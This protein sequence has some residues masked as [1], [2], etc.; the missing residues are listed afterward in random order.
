MNLPPPT[1][2]A[3]RSRQGSVLI[4]VLWVCVGLVSIALYFANTMGFEL[5]ASDN[6]VSGLQ[7]D[8]A[9][10]GAAR[11][12]GL[13]LLNFATNGTVPDNTQF[14]CEAVPVG[15]ARFWLLGRDPSGT[16]GP[17]PYFG[18]VD[19]GA[20]L[21]L[22]NASTNV[23]QYLPNMTIDFADAILDWRSTNGVV[24]LDYTSL[25]YQTK[26]APFETVDE[27]RLVYG[28]SLEFLA[29]E[30]VNR[31]GILDKNEKDLN[32]SGQLDPGLFEY[33]TVYTR[34]PNFHADGTTLTNVNTIS[35]SE[36]RSLFQNA[37]TSSAARMAQ[38]LYRSIHPN[39][40][41]PRTVN[42]CNGL[43][44][45]ALRCKN[46]GLS[47]DDFAKLEPNV[48][49]STNAYFRGRVNVN[50]AGVDVLTA[51]FMGAGQDEQTALSAA[52][53]LIT[54]R[55]QNLSRLGS[56]TW[57]IDALGNNQPIITAMARRNDLTTRSYQFTADIAA[58]GPFG[59]GYRRVK[60]I[61]DISDG[62]PK[63]LY[64]QD[65][66]RLGW[67]LGEKARTTL[68]AKNTQ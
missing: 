54:Y 22:N 51:L 13:A 57:V 10:E 12:V 41:N 30:D 58:V 35:E 28:S 44:D 63:I 62:T 2:N 42:N 1:L 4:I 52:Q 32:S 48:T 31:N 27:L 59:R 65:L 24:A 46:A 8:Q 56:I 6:R 3:R 15:D 49:T 55:E 11:Y 18:L 16:S 67:A 61:F 9:I 23:L 29:G 47:S 36:M 33:V 45:L 43:L 50:T 40:N 38:L 5:R 60:F 25:G 20:K 14:R 26:Y 37:G 7:A 19:E 64:R 68:L 34:E 53:T 21:S 66:S 39:P 17:E